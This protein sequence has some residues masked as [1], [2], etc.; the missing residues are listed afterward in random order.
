MRQRYLLLILALCWLMTTLGYAVEKP[1]LELPDGYQCIPA[2]AL[3]DLQVKMEDT[4]VIKLTRGTK[5][6][7]LIRDMAFNCVDGNSAL[8]MVDDYTFE[9]DGVVYIPLGILKE[10]GITIKVQQ[11]KVTLTAK[12]GKQL[13]T[14][15]QP[16]HVLSFVPKTPGCHPLVM[17]NSPTNSSSGW[18]LGG[19]SKGRWHTQEPMTKSLTGKEVFKVYTLSKHVDTVTGGK[20][21]LPEQGEGVEFELNKAVPTSLALACDWDALPRIPRSEKPTILYEKEIEKILLAHGVKPNG[22]AIVQQ[23]RVDLDGDGKDEVLLNARSK[24]NYEDQPKPG[25][26]R[27]VLVRK[28]IGTTVQTFVL[29]ASLC[30]QQVPFATGLT[31]QSFTITGVLDIDGDGQQEVEIYEQPGGCAGYTHVFK[32]AQKR[33][34]RVL[35]GG[36]TD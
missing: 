9:F 7:F 34:W 2:S 21:S 35:V 11:S 31:V 32:F 16:L 33:Y 15:T 14:V 36:F 20:A 5:S 23:L 17:F 29:T 30:P 10:L 3:A 8:A 27:I 26:F 22:I 1:A 13:M 4:G 19:L 12:D 18:L 25:N 28:L 24:E 6:I